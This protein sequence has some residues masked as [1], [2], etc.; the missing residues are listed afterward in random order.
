MAALPSDSDRHVAGRRFYREMPGKDLPYQ[1]ASTS[2][3]YWSDDG[4]VGFGD[5]LSLSLMPMWWYVE[6]VVVIALDLPGACGYRR[7]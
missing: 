5:R 3:A 4:G 1:S 2:S 7:R 6:R